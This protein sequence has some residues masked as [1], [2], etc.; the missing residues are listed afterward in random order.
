VEEKDIIYR[1]WRPQRAA[2]PLMV[3]KVIEGVSVHDLDPKPSQEVWNHSPDGF[4]WGY[5]G[6]GPAQLALALLLDVTGN[7]ALA[8]HW[9]HPFKA[10]LVAGWGDQW[11]ITRGDILDWINKQKAGKGES[12]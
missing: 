8:V 4:Q 7:S 5:G 11:E 12:K 10:Q 6:S 1:G 3:H 9:H 2:G